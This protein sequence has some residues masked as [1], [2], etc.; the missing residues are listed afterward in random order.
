[1]LRNLTLGAAFV[2]AA[3]ATTLDAGGAFDVTA[4]FVLGG[5]LLIV[6][7]GILVSAWWGRRRGLLLAAFL[8]SVGLAVSWIPGLSLA[9]GI[10][11]RVERPLAVTDVPKAYRLGIGDYRIDLTKLALPTSRTL[12]VSAGLGAGR[13]SIDVPR[14]A[15]VD[16]SGHISAGALQIDDQP[17]G[18]SGVDVGVHRHLPATSDAPRVAVHI[19]AAF[20]DVEVHRVP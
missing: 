15:Y 6:A 2:F 19:D 17:V 10:G 3:A 14:S 18:L 8:L 11:D 9:G 1:M 4:S 12:H 13:L 16:L 5:M 20:A 7:T